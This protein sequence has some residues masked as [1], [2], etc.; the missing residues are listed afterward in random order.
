MAIIIYERAKGNILWY[1]IHLKEEN[2]TYESIL[3]LISFDRIDAL[4]TFIG[5]KHGIVS[6]AELGMLRCAD[7]DPSVNAIQSQRPCRVIHT[8]LKT[9]IEPVDVDDRVDVY[10]NSNPAPIYSSSFRDA[11]Y[12]VGSLKDTYANPIRLTIPLAKE[13]ILHC[14]LPKELNVPC[15]EISADRGICKQRTANI[16]ADA[17]LTNR[18]VQFTISVVQETV[19]WNVSIYRVEDKGSKQDLMLRMQFQNIW[20]E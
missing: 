5:D 18:H 20:Q 13:I 2:R 15:V 9:A 3:K 12:E 16:P 4:S 19:F 6:G 17:S 11:R 7:N 8:S 14:Q 1:G 10:V